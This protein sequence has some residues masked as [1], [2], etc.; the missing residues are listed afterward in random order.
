MTDPTVRTNAPI[1]DAPP[2]SVLTDPQSVEAAL[3]QLA[4]QE[5]APRPLQFADGPEKEEEPSVPVAE[6]KAIPSAQTKTVT[7]PQPLRIPEATNDAAPS[8]AVYPDDMVF[9]RGR[10]VIFLRFRSTLTYTP[11]KGIPS[12]TEINKE[13]GTPVLY[14]HAIVWSL[15]VG[16]KRYAAGRSMSDPNRFSDE[17]VKSMIR[18]TDGNRVDLSDA[19]LDVWWDEVGEKVRGL[20]QRAYNQLHNLK[21]EE[22]DHFLEHCIEVRSAG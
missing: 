6:L 8:W 18:S 7:P 14:R 10:Q 5:S 21:V 17:L 4:E 2:G 13:D 20:L 15:S 3:K 22:L 9:P 16:D 1:P 11:K 19:S 12:K